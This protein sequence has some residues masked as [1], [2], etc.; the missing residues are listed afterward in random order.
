[1]MWF[2]VLSARYGVEDGRVR[3][4]GRE[5]SAWWRAI[6][7]LRSEEWFQ[8]NISQVVG[9]GKNT[10]FWTDNWLGG[11]CFRD[12]FT[13][14]YELSEFKGESVF[15][16]HLRGWV[17][18]GAAWSWRRRLFAWEE[19]L[20]G[21]LRLLLLNVS[22]QVDRSDRWMWRLEPSLGYTVRSSYNFIN[23]S[24]SVHVDPVLSVSSL[25]LKHVPL[26]VVLFVWR[27][28]QDRLPT[29]DNLF[30]RRV[31]N[32]DAQLCI[33]GCGEV[34]SSSHLLFHCKLFG[35]V[36]NHI[37]RWMGCI[38]V[39][40]LDAQSHYYQFSYIAGVA[41]SRRSIIQVIWFATVWE[42]WKERNNRIFNNMNCSIS[43][44]VDKIKSLTYMWLKGN[45]VSLPL[46]YHGWWLSPFSILGIG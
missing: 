31:I 41:L 44:V 1:M 23:S 21:E 11:V 3:E 18:D 43:Q 30:R 28:F 6:S 27:L 45:Y 38:A 4:G 15:N 42:I 10:M 14:L 12:R 40:P 37:L 20:E 26:K 19:E 9:D 17:E 7:A 22:L 29:K 33:G 13:R 36:W 34:E 2:R 46:N 25:W 5:A 16:M 35:S 24:A 32:F 8:G 39:L